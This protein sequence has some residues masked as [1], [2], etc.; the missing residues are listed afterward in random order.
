MHHPPPWQATQARLG[1]NHDQFA[2]AEQCSLSFNN[3]CELSFESLANTDDR[4]SVNLR[5]ARLRNGDLITFFSEGETKSPTPAPV[6]GASFSISSSSSFVLRRRGKG[7]RHR[8]RRSWRRDRKNSGFLLRNSC[9][10]FID[11]ILQSCFALHS[12]LKQLRL[13]HELGL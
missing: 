10:N 6:E 3:S 7:N 8:R 4:D 2:R 5:E 11:L 13:L 12:F 9:L 1:P